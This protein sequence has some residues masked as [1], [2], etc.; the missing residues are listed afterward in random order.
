M[1]SKF[2]KAFLDAPGSVD[3][4]SFAGFKYEWMAKV[5]PSLRFWDSDAPGLKWLL[6]SL[7]H[8]E[9]RILCE[10]AIC[11]LC[12]KMLM[13]HILLNLRPSKRNF[14]TQSGFEI[15][16]RSCFEF[17][18]TNSMIHCSGKISS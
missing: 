1:K 15:P 5:D 13:K 7:R 14:S 10:G 12:S 6:H 9:V 18:I 3:R 8:D 4:T 16:S 2:F 17:S 11:R